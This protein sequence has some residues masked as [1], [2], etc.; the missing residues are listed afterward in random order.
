MKKSVPGVVLSLVLVSSALAALCSEGQQYY[1]TWQQSVTALAQ[2]EAALSVAQAAEQAAEEERLSCQDDVVNEMAVH[3]CSDPAEC[4]TLQ[5]LLD[6]LGDAYDYEGQCEDAVTAAGQHRD[7][8]AQVEDLCS[9]AWTTHY[10]GCI[11]C[12]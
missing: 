1:S 5:D 2:A 3:G 8:M 11:Y 9:Q 12:Q 10:S 6:A 7:S 4:S